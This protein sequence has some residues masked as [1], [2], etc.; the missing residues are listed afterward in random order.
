M[1]IECVDIDTNYI[2]SEPLF[3]YETITLSLGKNY[4]S[5]SV[6]LPTKRAV[7]VLLNPVY[8]I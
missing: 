7:C 5:S 4:S 2:V 3:D 1:L 8:R 6:P